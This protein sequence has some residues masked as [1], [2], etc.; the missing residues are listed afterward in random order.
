MSR[1]VFLETILRGIT[2]TEID[3]KVAYSYFFGSLQF[4]VGASVINPHLNYD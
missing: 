3:G 2:A 4:W 1:N